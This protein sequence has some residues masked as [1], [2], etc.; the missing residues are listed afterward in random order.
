LKET[1]ERWSN[2]NKI[3]RILESTTISDP[4]GV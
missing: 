3:S 4:K 1:R 2:Y